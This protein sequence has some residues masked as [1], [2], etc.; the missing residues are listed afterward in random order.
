MGFQTLPALLVWIMPGTSK[1]GW[2]LEQCRDRELPKHAGCVITIQHA[3]LTTKSTHTMSVIALTFFSPLPVAPGTGD[4]FGKR[5]IIL[6]VR[7]EHSLHYQ[8]V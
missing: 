8:N 6:P 5:S 7:R 3:I 4:G 2:E 1:S